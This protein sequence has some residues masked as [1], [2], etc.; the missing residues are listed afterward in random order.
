MQI[1]KNPTFAAVVAIAAT[2]LFQTPLPL[3]GDHGK[4]G[5]DDEGGDHDQR[6]RI[7]FNKSIRVRL[8]YENTRVS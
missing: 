5:R 1:I 6:V 4:R 7:T 2:L 8:I 3:F